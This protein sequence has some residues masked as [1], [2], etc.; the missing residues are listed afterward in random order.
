MAVEEQHRPEQSKS[1]IVGLGILWILLAL[2]ILALQ[3]VVPAK[4]DIEWETETEID[5]AGFNIYRS[6]SAE[7]E[8]VR[9]NP[10]IIPSQ[11]DAVS[12]ATYLYTDKNVERGKTYYYQLE[13]IEYDN[14]TQQ[15]DI[16]TGQVE[17]L[18]W[19]T[20]PLTLVSGIIGVIML[21]SGLRQNRKEK[22]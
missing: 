11:S 1:I 8:F 21:V 10:Q 18:N 5:T 12:G 6:N 7:G 15:H 17:A 2:A 4:I 3:F 22:Q 16:L 9:I 14:S 19:W 13:D 20:I